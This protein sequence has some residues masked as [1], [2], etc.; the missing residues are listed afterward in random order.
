MYI[1]HGDKAYTTGKEFAVGITVLTLFRPIKAI[2]VRPIEMRVLVMMEKVQKRS[3]EFLR[4]QSSNPFWRIAMLL[5]L[6][7]LGL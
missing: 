3:L 1:T 4:R 2:L 5:S 6:R 7:R